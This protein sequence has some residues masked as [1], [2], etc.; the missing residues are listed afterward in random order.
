M[1]TDKLDALI[2]RNLRDVDLAAKRIDNEIEPRIAKALDDIVGSWAKRHRWDGAFG[3]EEDVLRVMPPDWR[4]PDADEEKW[5]SYFKLY[6]GYGD[7]FSGEGDQDYFW[8]TR[9]CGVGNGKICF[10]W[11]YGDALGATKPKWKRFVQPYV[12]SIRKVG[13]EYEDGS[14]LFFI[15]VRVD[16]EKLASVIEENNIEEALQPVRAAL[17][18]LLSAKPQFDGMLKDAKKQ[19]SD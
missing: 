6:A 10:R 7:D 14:G 5:F 17:D 15:P 13:F 2:I 1:L 4:S 3:W 11:E 19:F 12:Q 18:R 8:L 16:A 9:F